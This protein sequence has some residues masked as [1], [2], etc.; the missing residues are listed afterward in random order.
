MQI[1]NPMT[2]AELDELVDVLGD[3]GIGS[4]LD[5]ACG[6]G[7]LLVRAAAAMPLDGTGIDLSP[8]MI[9][10]AHEQ[11]SSR[12]GE[13][14]LRFVLGE[15]KDFR[16]DAPVDAAI[17]I[18]AEWVWHDFSG[19]VRALSERCAPGGL[20][21][22]GAARLHVAADQSTVRR[23]HGFVESIDDMAATLKQHNLEPVHRIDPNDAGWDSYLERTRHAARA[24]ATLYPGERSDQWLTEQADWHDARER[25]R[26]VIGWSV[27][28]ARRS[29]RVA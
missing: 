13:H 8:W 5:V 18:G 16:P 28:V 29:A 6:Y 10:A 22:V 25:D 23:T 15:A 1:C 24:W 21:V 3:H 4:M 9:T 11:A 12:L 14:R 26:D 2:G 20:V 19:T 17:C 7:E 27:W